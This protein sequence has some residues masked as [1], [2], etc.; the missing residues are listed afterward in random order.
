MTA[1]APSPLTRA[2]L[3]DHK[4][5]RLRALVAEVI[6]ANAFYAAK[7]AGEVPRPASLDAL[8][9]WPLTTKAELVA[10]SAGGTPANLT[11]PPE[12]YVRYHRTSGTHGR[13]MPVFDTAADWAWWLECWDA[14]LA[15]ADVGPGDRVLVAS[16]FGPFIGF[17]S[18][19][20]GA[21]KRGA[22]VIPTGGM[23]SLARLQVAHDTRA[24]VLMATPSYALHLAEVA[25][26]AKID[27]AG[28]PIRL[29]I[30]AGEPGGSIPQVR[31]RIGLEWDAR[32]LDHAGSSEVGP[33]GVG[34]RHGRHL[35]VLEPWFHPEFLS[36][37]TGK[38]AAAGELAELVL[39]T[40]GRVGAPLIR[41]RTGDL[42]RA[43]W[44][45]DDAAGPPWVRLA[46]G[47]VGRADDMLVVR[48]I[49]VFPG[50]VDGIVRGFPE[51][52]EYR[53]S[54][55]RR[56]SLDELD[57]E[58]EDR[59]DDPQRVEREFHLRLGLRVNVTVVPPGTL[60]RFEGK[61]NRVVDTRGVTGGPG[62]RRS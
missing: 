58:I 51:V 54:V 12:R 28:L 17:W 55:A 2:A 40:L 38:P 5:G 45:A 18:G 22:M 37:A 50:A 11:F 52:S 14:I 47:I 29:V 9:D 8:A 56:R 7:F 20:E 60:P 42:V 49:N 1:S 6:P 46:G 13:P 57:L 19:F 16:S 36:P 31:D 23:S 32:V 53:L 39:T 10:G 61:G 30:V 62:G 41:Y 15:R 21:E 33:W 44:P 26:Q 24:T 3:D 35:E 59:L 25:A 34:D 4:L 27:I 48:G 43:S